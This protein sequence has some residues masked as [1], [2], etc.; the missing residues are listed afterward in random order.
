MHSFYLPKYG[1]KKILHTI[2]H[3]HSIYSQRIGPKVSF[4]KNREDKKQFYQSIFTCQ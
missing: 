2:D 3:T 1:E 4:V